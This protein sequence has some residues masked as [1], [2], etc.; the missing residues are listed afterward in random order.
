VSADIVLDA[1]TDVSAALLSFLLQAATAS[2]ATASMASLDP[3]FL[4]NMFLS[5]FNLVKKTA[6]VSKAASSAWHSGKKRTHE[7]V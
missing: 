1:A 7:R 5:P 2:V 4:I 6:A 3:D